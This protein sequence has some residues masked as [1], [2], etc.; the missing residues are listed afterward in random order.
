[1][2]EVQEGVEVL[3]AVPFLRFLHPS[4]GDVSYPFLLQLLLVVA[5]IF[6]C[7]VGADFLGDHL[8]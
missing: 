8:S 2:V 5:S 7:L 4:S 6:C 1:M 3:Q